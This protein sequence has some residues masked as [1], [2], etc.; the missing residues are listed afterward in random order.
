LRRFQV[1]QSEPGRIKVILAP[2]PA[3]PV[4]L[5]EKVRAEVSAFSGLDVVVIRGGDFVTSRE[6]KC[7]AILQQVRP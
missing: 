6:G 3:A 2:G 1:V 7:P 5:A 4:D